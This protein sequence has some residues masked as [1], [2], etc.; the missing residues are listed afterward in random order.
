MRAGQTY[1]D[2]VNATTEQI[3]QIT[4]EADGVS[5]V[6]DETVAEQKQKET[7]INEINKEKAEINEQISSSPPKYLKSHY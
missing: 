3:N 5:T 2:L 7:Q 6:I 4:Q 1:D